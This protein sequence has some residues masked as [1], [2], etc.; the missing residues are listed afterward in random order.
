M[1]RAHPWQKV[2]P[3]SVLGDGH[4]PQKTADFGNQESAL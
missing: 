3:T 2:A 4:V 1:K